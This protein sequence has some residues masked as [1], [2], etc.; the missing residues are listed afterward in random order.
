MVLFIPLASASAQPKYKFEKIV[1][2]LSEPLST[3]RTKPKKWPGL[4]SISLLSPEQRNQIAVLLAK[5]MLEEPNIRS[6]YYRSLIIELNRKRLITTA[7]VIPILN[8]FAV[9]AGKSISQGRSAAWY[10]EHLKY[11]SMDR[12]ITTPEVLPYL[13]EA[14][15]NPDPGVARPAFS[16]LTDLTFHYTGRTNR[17]GSTEDPTQHRL[18]SQWWK[19]WWEKNKDR[20]PV[21]DLELESG[22]KAEMTMLATLIKENLRPKFSEMSYFVVTDFRGHGQPPIYLLAYSPYNYSFTFK[23]RNIENV[24]LCMEADFQTRDLPDEGSTN[25]D[26]RGFANPRYP[27]PHLEN[28][29]QEIYLR[30][31][32]G[33]D[34]FI[35]VRF[36]SNNQT[37]IDALRK[38]MEQ[39]IDNVSR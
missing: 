25:M 4:K 20:K 16:A 22:V 17:G 9:F 34:V 5:S 24:W 36:A 31:I 37:L 26:P 8:Q 11:L 13:I 15:D 38:L 19:D 14:L 6:S 3:L 10:A 35:R 23:P 7:E 18:V 12:L 2:I 30:T 32:P 28:L 39:A 21:F 33:T 27:P 1:R 29:E